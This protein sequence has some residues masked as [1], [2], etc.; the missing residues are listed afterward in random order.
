MNRYNNF[1]S[2]VVV[3]VVLA[4]VECWWW[5]WLQFGG[6][7]AMGNG[8]MS[9]KCHT[10]MNCIWRWMYAPTRTYIFGAC[11]PFVC[12][13][14]CVCIKLIKHLKSNLFPFY[15]FLHL[16]DTRT[17]PP[18]GCAMKIQRSNSKSQEQTFFST[19]H[20]PNDVTP[21][22][23]IVGYKH[24]FIYIERIDGKFIN[25]SMIIKNIK[26][27]WSNTSVEKEG[28]KFEIQIEG[29]SYTQCN[30]DSFRNFSWQVFLHDT[31]AIQT[32]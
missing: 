31:F 17:F 2:F 12:V 5:W 4:F 19:T 27:K 26:L 25:T 7:R 32:S 13:C 3:L 9:G 23:V 29:P 24:I 10:S 16:F 20:T 11:V 8:L 18:C 21:S 30:A 14:V 15:S 6:K 22:C 28:N 1:M